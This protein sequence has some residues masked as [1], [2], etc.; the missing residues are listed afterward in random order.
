MTRLSN[1]QN[2]AL[3][4]VEMEPSLMLRSV[5]VGLSCLLA[6]IP[7]CLTCSSSSDC[8]QCES[9]FFSQPSSVA[10]ESTCPSRHFPNPSTRVCEAC[11]DPHCL[12]CSSDKNI[13]SSCSTDEKYYLDGSTC[14]YCPDPFLTGFNSCMSCDQTGY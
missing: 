7:N 6:C 4:L 14:S 8:S 13:C 1:P 10:C 3:P 2:T 12:D 11:S 9:G 5:E